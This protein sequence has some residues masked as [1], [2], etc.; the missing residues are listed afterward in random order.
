MAMRPP[1]RKSR[2]HGEPEW[3]DLRG[4]NL[5]GGCRN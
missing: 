5:R 2:G 1:A 3:R 4:L